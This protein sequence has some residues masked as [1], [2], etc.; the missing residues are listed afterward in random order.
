MLLRIWNSGSPQEITFSFP[1][2]HL[3]VEYSQINN[4]PIWQNQV[5][6]A[7]YILYGLD[8]NFK[9]NGDILIVTEHSEF[10]VK[11]NKKVDTFKFLLSS[12]IDKNRVEVRLGNKSELRT[13]NKDDL[14]I[15]SFSAVQPTYSDNRY[16]LY[17]LSISSDKHL[18]KPIL[19]TNG[20]APQVNMWIPLIY[21]CY[22][23][24]V[25]TT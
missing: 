24:M 22:C 23:S 19:N 6:Y 20:S 4:L 14:H 3:P 9:H 2:K 12:K 10:L 11:A 1:Y 5:R 21:H 8:T 17:D 15:I 13:L 18:P 25:G 16:N 7:D